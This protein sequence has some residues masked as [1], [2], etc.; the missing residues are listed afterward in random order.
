MPSLFHINV[1]KQVAVI[2]GLAFA[3][4]LI[5]QHVVISMPNWAHSIIDVLIAVFTAAGIVPAFE[6]QESKK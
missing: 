6:I 2:L 3:T 5:V 4:L 1:S